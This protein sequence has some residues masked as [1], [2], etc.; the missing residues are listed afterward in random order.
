MLILASHLLMANRPARRRSIDVLGPDRQ[1]ASVPC[2][3]MPTELL[4]IVEVDWDDR[5]RCQ[6]PDCGRSVHKAV[7]VILD[8][9]RLLVYGSTCSAEHFGFGIGKAS[10]PRYGSGM[11]RKLTKEERVLLECNTAALVERMEAEYV[12]ELAGRK[13]EEDALAASR[14]AEEAQRQ[15]ASRAV[16]DE[17]REGWGQPRRRDEWRQLVN[18]PTGTDP[19]SRW[20]AQQATAAA[21]SAMQR[22]P[23]LARFSVNEVATAMRQAKEQCLAAGLRMDADGAREAIERGAVALLAHY[24]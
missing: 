4:A 24:D 1:D 17:D 10:G 21:K 5:I 18:V 22:S 9:G 16:I 7:H 20:R 19:L 8:G 6:A 23:E 2:T 14:T 11:G 12:A 13:A 3:G 15:A